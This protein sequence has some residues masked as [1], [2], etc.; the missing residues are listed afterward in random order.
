MNEKLEEEW[1]AGMK[2]A[3]KQCKESIEKVSNL[4]EIG[5][6]RVKE[7]IGNRNARERRLNG[8]AKPTQKKVVIAGG[9]NA[10]ALFAKTI[11]R[12]TMDGPTYM[13]HLSS[14]WEKV[15]ENDRVVFREEAK[16][17]RQDPYKGKPRDAVIL[18]QLKI[19]NHA[20]SVY[21]A[22]L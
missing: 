21:L 5:T 19:I 6:E 14:E 7:W 2:H 12:G 20:V 1:K 17:I 3:G 11:K 4:L 22:R 16:K 10:Y 15:E 18:S 13:R 8:E 9:T